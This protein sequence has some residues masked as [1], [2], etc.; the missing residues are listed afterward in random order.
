MR[1]CGRGLEVHVTHAAAM[2]V[3]GMAAS[4]FGR[5]AT[6]ASVV[7]EQRRDRGGVLQRG[8][9]DLGRVDDARP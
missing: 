1:R 3:A 2:G 5:S 4:F 7:I 6:I 8:A 9:H